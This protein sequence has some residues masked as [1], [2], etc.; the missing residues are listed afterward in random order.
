MKLNN[1]V[2]IVKY[3]IDFNDPSKDGN[4]VNDKPITNSNFPNDWY[5]ECTDCGQNVGSFTCRLR[6]INIINN[7]NAIPVHYVNILNSLFLLNLT[8]I[9][10][11][12]VC[13]C[14]YNEIFV[15]LSTSQYST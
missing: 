14:Y 7:I 15:S 4:I 1:L 13:L 10:P 5:K 2:S 12:T 3:I 8:P 9:L 11:N 6:G